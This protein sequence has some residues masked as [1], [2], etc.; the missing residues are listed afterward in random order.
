MG[1]RFISFCA[2]AG[3]SA[4]VSP[5]S[6]SDVQIN[7]KNAQTAAKGAM[8]PQ[9]L[10]PKANTY[11]LLYAIQSKS[12]DAGNVT[13][14]F[15]YEVQRFEIK[16]LIDL[17]SP[18]FI[19]IEDSRFPGL[20]VT[21]FANK[22]GEQVNIKPDDIAHA[23]PTATQAEIDSVVDANE[24]ISHLGPLQGVVSVVTDVSTAQYGAFATKCV[25]DG[26][27]TDRFPA[28]TCT[29]DASN[30]QRLQLC[31]AFWAEHPEFYEGSD[32]VFTL[33]LNG[34]FRG[35]VDGANPVNGGFIGGAEWV[36][37]SVLEDIDS[38]TVRWQFKDLD[39]NGTPDYA[40]DTPEGDKKLGHLYMTG[41]PYRITRGVI[42][43]RL[44]NSDDPSIVGEMAVFPAVGD[45]GTNF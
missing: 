30:K 11:Y 22:V 24:R 36:V 16:S 6:G 13:Q 15:V 2:L 33:P 40:A 26:G 39:G 21:Q 37:P 38:Y 35:V 28:P 12:D 1:V 3:A 17:S 31:K 9:P 43:V 42:N 34:T 4:C 44:A 5:L 8:A 29:G 45:R 18:C 25:E 14:Q 10:Q 7:F 27:E 23:P 20:H 41:V 32:K 19:D